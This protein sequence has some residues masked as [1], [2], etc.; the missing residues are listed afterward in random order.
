MKTVAGKT[1]LA[2]LLF[3]ALAGCGV[4]EPLQS[5]LIFRPSS[6]QR[7]DPEASAA[8]LTEVW[9]DYRSAINDEAVRLHALWHPAPAADSAPL[10][11]FLHGA[12]WD[13][14]ASAFRIRELQALGFSVLGIDYRGFGKSTP[15]TPSETLAYE[16]AQAAWTWLAARYPQR[17]RFIYGHSLGSAIAIDLASR[18]D[19]EAGTLV[20]GAFT[21]IPDVFASFRLGWLPLAP[22]ITQ[23]FAAVDKVA[24][25]KSPLLVIHGSDDRIIDPE[26]GQR[27]YTAALPPKRFVLIAGGTH[28]NSQRKGQEQMRAALAELFGLVL[29]SKGN[30]LSADAP[31]TSS[32]DS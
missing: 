14:A 18:N 23:R 31:R 19:D 29:S 30:Q 5:Q 9:I 8:P 20:E 7:S 26:L 1:L 32:G 2:G 11:L 21:S 17:R 15:A 12:R 3:T 28:R 25:I 4:M 22:L 13:I 10:L 16:D 27:L 24:S 6:E